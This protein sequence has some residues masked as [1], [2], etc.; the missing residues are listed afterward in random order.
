MMLCMELKIIIAKSCSSI[1]IILLCN[2]FTTLGENIRY[3]KNN[4]NI[5]GCER[6]ESITSIT[7]K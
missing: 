1:A 6:Y 3:V 4:C 5:D 2:S 7:R